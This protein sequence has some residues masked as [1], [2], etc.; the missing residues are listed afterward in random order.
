MNFGCYQR[1]LTHQEPIEPEAEK[2]SRLKASKDMVDASPIPLIAKGNTHVES[3]KDGTTLEDFTHI[4][5][6]Q[7]KMTSLRKY[8]QS[9]FLKYRNRT[10][11]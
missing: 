9:K 10:H 8:P 4:N 5:L 7:A 1:L 6:S 2:L 11:K 3:Q